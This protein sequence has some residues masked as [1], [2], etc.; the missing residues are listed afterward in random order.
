MGHF[1]VLVR[2]FEEGDVGTGTG[3]LGYGLKGNRLRFQSYESRRVN[4]TLGGSGAV[5]FRGDRGPGS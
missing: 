5:Q 3:T 1:P 4:Y 2:I